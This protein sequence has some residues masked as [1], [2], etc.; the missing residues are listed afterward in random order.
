MLPHFG[1]LTFGFGIPDAR[2][3]EMNPP[4]VGHLFVISLTSY[5]T[6]ANRAQFSKKEKRESSYGET[7][8]YIA[9]LFYNIALKWEF[10]SHPRHHYNELQSS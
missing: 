9:N 8:L 6:C 7:K 10:K 3:S 1:H 5:Q 2:S 4:H